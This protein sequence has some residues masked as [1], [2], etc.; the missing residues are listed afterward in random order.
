M[1]ILGAMN[2]RVMLLLIGVAVFGVVSPLAAHH[3]S[4]MFDHEKVVE[5]KG[6][7]KEF[8][9]T[10]P[11]VWIQ[12]NVETPDGVAEWSVEGGGPN[13]LSRQ[14][15]RPSTFKAGT[16]VTLR[17]NPMLDGTPAGGFVGAQFADGSTLGRWN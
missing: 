14:G 16:E 6:V 17:I 15:W 8:Q 7:V 3:S 13:S 10:N 9:W 2:R 5:I 4:A 1:N 12:V 11:H